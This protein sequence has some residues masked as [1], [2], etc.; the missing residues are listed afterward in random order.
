MNL[1]SNDDF[2]SLRVHGDEN[3]NE[4]LFGQNATIFEI[5]FS[6]FA[7]GGAIHVD[8]TNIELAHLSGDSIDHI[9][10]GAV[11]S[12]ES[13]F[14]RNT[15]GNGHLR[16]SAE[17]ACFTVDGHDLSRFDDVVAVEELTG[18]GVSRDVDF[19]VAFVDDV[20]TQVDESIDYSIH[21]VLVT[22]NEAGSEDDGVS[23]A[24]LNR[25]VL[26]VCHAGQARHRFTLRACSHIEHS[27]I[28]KLYGLFRIH[29]KTVGN[30]QV[31]K[32]L[33]DTH[34]AHH[35]APHQCHETIIGGCRIN[36]LL[37]SVHVGSKTRDDNPPGCSMNNLIQDGSD[38]RFPR[39]EAGDVGVGGVHQEKVHALFPEPRERPKIGQ[40]AIERELIHLEVARV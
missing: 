31:A 39:S 22:G 40:A 6:D 19:G 14:A 7:N 27:L 11:F 8:E 9:H 21:R 26:P 13:A 5:G 38:I 12:D 10:D 37:H 17:V 36:D 33:G 2:S 32:F 34:V 23:R 30:T 20:G 24:N 16:V 29:Q 15:R 3:G 1:G 25:G 18:S 4:A 28:R 35:G